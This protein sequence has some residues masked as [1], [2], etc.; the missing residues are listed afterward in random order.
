MYVEG[1]VLQNRDVEGTGFNALVLS[2]G[3]RKQKFACCQWAGTR[4]AY[5][6]GTG[7]GEEGAGLGWEDFQVNRL[8]SGQRFEIAP[9]MRDFLDD[10]GMTLTH[11]TP[12]RLTLRDVF[13]F[14]DLREV[15][16]LRQVESHY[17]RGDQITNLIAEHGNLLVT[18]DD[19][20]GKTA[21]AKML[22]Q[23][24][25]E[26]GYVP[27]FVDG[28]EKLPSDDRI[29]AQIEAQFAEQYSGAALGAYRQLDRDRRVL[30]VDD[31]HKL[32]HK[33][34]AKRK[35]V[36][37][38]VQFAAR[39]V[40]LAHDLELA[41]MDWAHPE[42]LADGRARFMCYRILPSGHVGGNRIVERWL[43]HYGAE[44]DVEDAALVHRLAWIFRAP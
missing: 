18:G 35:L 8:R 19:Q 32:P 10:P 9:H 12:E 27:V 29:Y 44:T 34:G 23:H 43:T 1:Y 24:L 41:A 20:S 38:T 28:R 33:R 16:C 22:L 5:G 21:L 11:R 14:P 26:Q 39:V 2:T 6:P 17:V 37:N 40:L 42:S 13:V 3:A 4:Y 15:K 31:Y 25:H 36:G 30:I 7:E